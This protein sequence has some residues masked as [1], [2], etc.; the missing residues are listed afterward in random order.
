[1]NAQT[2]DKVSSIAARYVTMTARRLNDLS[3]D[4]ATAANA[5]ADIRSMAASLLRQDETKGIRGLFRKLRG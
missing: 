1:M 5:A 2:S 4:P 3:A